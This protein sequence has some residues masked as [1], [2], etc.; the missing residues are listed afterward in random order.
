[1]MLVL[2]C[3]ISYT[4]VSGGC[5]CGI[6]QT[7]YT[8]FRINFKITWMFKDIRE[9][10]DRDVFFCFSQLMTLSQFYRQYSQKQAVY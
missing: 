3:S 2:L 9:T 5:I 10:K 8:F 7:L 1:M 4:P 6:P